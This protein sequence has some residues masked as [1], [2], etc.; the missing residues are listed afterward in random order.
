MPP[1]SLFCMISCGQF[2]LTR[3]ARPT[4]TRSVF[5]PDINS[6]R[7]NIKFNVSNEPRLFEPEDMRVKIGVLHEGPLLEDSS[8]TIH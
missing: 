1:D 4:D 3:R 6:L 5:H 2:A 8:Y 7:L